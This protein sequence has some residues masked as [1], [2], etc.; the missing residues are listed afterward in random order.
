MESQK[1]KKG[2]VAVY[3][4]KIDGKAYKCFLR[5]RS[6]VGCI[7]GV[8][9]QAVSKQVNNLIYVAEVYT[10]QIRKYKIMVITLLVSKELLRVRN[11]YQEIKTL[12]AKEQNGN[13]NYSFRW[14]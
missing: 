4:A 9:L 14:F 5:T 12:H 8:N 10:K 13:H 1:H 2:E 11:F 7:I 3:A 6:G